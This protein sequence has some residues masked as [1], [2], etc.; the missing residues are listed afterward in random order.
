MPGSPQHR[1]PADSSTRARQVGILILLLA[2]IAMAVFVGTKVLTHPG[3]TNTTT[4]I[5]PLS[6]T[7]RVSTTTTTIDPATLPQTDAEPPS[8]NEALEVRLAP[9][10]RAIQSGNL[11]LAQSVFFPESAYLSMKKG[12]ISDPTRDYSSRLF[13]FLKLDLATYH[14]ALGAT[15][16]SAALIETLGQASY[17][18]WIQPSACENNVGYWHLPGVRLVYR[19]GGQVRSF[20][21]ASL[22]SWRG[23]WYVVHLGPNPRPYDVGTLDEPSRGPGIPGPPGGC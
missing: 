14:Q 16:R 2:L 8:S 4:S 22:I 7:T 1:K 10:W 12:R 3:S 20:G 13:A 11:A 15:P 5:A 23:T 6:T 18:T 9:L 19:L 17:S 21:V